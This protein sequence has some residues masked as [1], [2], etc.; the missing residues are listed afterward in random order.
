MQAD[1]RRVARKRRSIFWDDPSVSREP[2]LPVECTA[3]EAA[4]GL[5]ISSASRETWKETMRFAARSS[6]PVGAWLLTKPPAVTIP[7][8]PARSYEGV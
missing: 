8:L 1:P 4:I 5:R 2:D 3:C 6:L 7:I